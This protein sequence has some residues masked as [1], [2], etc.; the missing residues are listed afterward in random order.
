LFSEEEIFFEDSTSEAVLA[1]I[2]TVEVKVAIVDDQMEKLNTQSFSPEVRTFIPN[3]LY[4]KLFHSIT[5]I[6]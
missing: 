2:G 3:I 1:P 5:S 6:F 4:L